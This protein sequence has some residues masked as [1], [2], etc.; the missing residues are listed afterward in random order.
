MSAIEAARELLTS[1]YRAA[2]EAVSAPAAIARCVEHDHSGLS[3]EGRIVPPD[4]RLFVLAAGKA[5][6]A[7]AEAFEGIAGDRI[8]DGLV[9][10]KDDH[11]EGFALERFELREAAHPIPDARCEMAAQ[12]ALD[13]ASQTGP[14]DRLVVLL[15]GGASALL[16][17]PLPGLEGV[18]LI[19][20]NELLLACGADIADINSVRKHLSRVAGG[21]LAMA[22]AARH[23]EVLA[24]SDV[25]GDRPDVIASGPFSPDSSR[26]EDALAILERHDLL[27]SAPSRVVCHLRDGVAG[28]RPETPKPGDPRLA[29]V[30]YTIVASNRDALVAASDRLSRSDV[31]VV[32]HE[33][34]LSGE[35][36]EAAEQLVGKAV[37][38]PGAGSHVLVAG[39][40]T[41]VK[42]RGDGLGGR[43]QELALAAALAIARHIESG[44]AREILVLAA[45]TDG[46]DGPTAAAGAWAD[47]GTLRR[48]EA[49]GASATKSLEDN[50]SFRFFAAEGG[51][52][53][54]GPS[55]TNV[56]DLVF[57]WV[58]DSA[59]SA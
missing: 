58:G 52:L 22:A 31:S 20:V 34:L 11:A 32:M 12:A 40:E 36:R 54:T 1:G 56:M 17:A 10:T 15:S 39:G 35:A 14:D 45:G 50:D 13:F 29:G 6:A 46:T 59:E 16:S 48:A 44:F 28:T 43:N 53:T 42:L 24:I 8:H 9:I 4:A 37:A 49:A 55:G 51:L 7:M 23:I 41:T 38:L 27:A 21:R 18:D 30:H 5:A 2:I 3:I 57:I 47:R 19:R 25:P 26:F 33:S